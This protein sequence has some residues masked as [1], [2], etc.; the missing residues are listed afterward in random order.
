[1][2][3]F[4]RILWSV[5]VVG[6]IV[7]AIVGDIDLLPS[8]DAQK[9]VALACLKRAGFKV[10]SNVPGSG[11]RI[12]AYGSEVVW[13]LDVKDA[14]G[15]RVAVIYLADATEDLDGFADNLKENQK[16]YGD[17]KGETIEHRSSSVMRMAKGHERAIRD[18]VD[19]AAKAK[20]T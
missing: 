14:D 5:L 15:R 3:F 8:A 2:K 16:V 12:P 20:E 9:P 18:C 19:Q 1:L 17:Y 13:E 6:G 11:G 7:Y 10:E 4:G